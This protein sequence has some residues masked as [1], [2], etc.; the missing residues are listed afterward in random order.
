MRSEAIA[1]KI[2]TEVH[3]GVKDFMSET[4]ANHRTLDFGKIEEKVQGLSQRFIRQLAEGALEAIGNGY[5]G[6]TIECEC[7]GFMEYCGDNRWLLTSL[8]GKLEIHRAYY[9]C[10]SCK[11]GFAPL[12]EQ[13]GLEGKHHS[14]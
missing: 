9:Y 13:L 14:I 3:E 2:M 8:S 11:S 7:G 12:D 5:V 1:E 4:I 10:K 6:R